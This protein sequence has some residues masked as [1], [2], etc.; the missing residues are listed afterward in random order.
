MKNIIMKWLEQLNK[1][2]NNNIVDDIEIDYLGSSANLELSDNYLI[3]NDTG[4]KNI[5]A[6][7]N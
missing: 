1:K 4:N 3:D 5:G 7:T 6:C 2:N